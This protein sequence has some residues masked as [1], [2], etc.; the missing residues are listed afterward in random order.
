MLCAQSNLLPEKTT[1]SSDNTTN[2]NVT[3]NN[4]SNEKDDTL[5]YA[6][7]I[8]ILMLFAMFLL[9]LEIAIIPG[10]GI[11]GI[12]GIILLLISLGLSFWK[13]SKGMAMAVTVIA[14]IGVVLL[15]CFVI[16]VLPETKLG[17]K[18]ILKDTSNSVS[19]NTEFEVD[20]LSKY[21]GLEGVALSN[22]RPSGLVKILDERVDIVSDG[23]FIEKGTKVKVIKTSSGKIVVTPLE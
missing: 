10:F 11:A 1:V 8:I 23:S 7:V 17:N 5:V 4:T 16:W 18:F 21:L 22:L 12:S 20:G 14:L 15:I 2:T 6:G 13:L 19:D 3:T 9:F